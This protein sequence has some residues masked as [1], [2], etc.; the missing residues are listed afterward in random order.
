MH[1]S[2]N[3][4]RRVPEEKGPFGKSNRRRGFSRSR[5]APPSRKEDLVKV[6]NLKDIDDIFTKYKANL[7][8][9]QQSKVITN[10]SGDVV[11]GGGGGGGGVTSSNNGSN[12]KSS[13]HTA[14][15][16]EPTEVVLYGYGA[17][18]QYAAIEFYERV[19]GGHVYE[20]YDRFPPTSRY[21][22]N[23]SHTQ[24][25]LSASLSGAPTTTAAG[26]GSSSP[27]S[28][29]RTSQSPAYRNN[30]LGSRSN[31][32]NNAV[33]SESVL[34]KKNAYVGGTHWI[35]VTFDSPRAAEAACRC[36]PHVICGYLVHAQLFRG[37]LLPA[38][39]AIPAAANAS[40][41]MGD[42]LTASPNRS[43]GTGTT[44]TTSTLSGDT[45]RQQEHLQQDGSPSSSTATSATAT[46]PRPG[47]GQ[48]VTM[49]D[50]APSGQA[51]P[52]N[53]YNNDNIS[54]PSLAADAP[55][56]NLRQAWSSGAA[57]ATN[58][59]NQSTPQS[60]SSAKQGQAKPRSLRIQGAKPAVLLP[61]DQ[62]LLPVIPR[63]QRTLAKIP[64]AS[65]LVDTSG[66]HGAGALIAG[67]GSGSGS[68]VIGSQVPRRESD[69][70]F[71]WENA[72]L[73]WKGWW[74]VDRVFGSDFCG[75]EE[76]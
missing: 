23:L 37:S 65:L 69:G 52:G 56:S 51:R 70:A 43:D 10:A 58:I 28:F 55:A 72:S 59:R 7:S 30:L 71:D 1:S 74:M 75:I 9:G 67:S 42:G 64:L 15:L 18:V 19:S 32:S 49:T 22:L 48:D 24:A 45:L 8:E 3:F 41:M 47:Q 60:S 36:S 4:Q 5:T 2:E 20:D 39:A 73:Y 31:S 61:A 12:E 63:W 44:R 53:R 6:E 17:D 21:S 46:G 26:F 76:S 40:G 68:E 35:K 16:A 62:A 57:T 14:S 34:R 29:N 11:V 33:L 54:Y 25:S 27:S 38:D 66:H 50:A 13:Q